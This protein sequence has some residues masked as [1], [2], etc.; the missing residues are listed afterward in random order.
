MHAALIGG[1]IVLV[2]GA[3]AKQIAS[4]SIASI[5]AQRIMQRAEDAIE[6][7]H[8]SLSVEGVDLHPVDALALARD[9]FSA[10]CEM[11][12]LKAQHVQPSVV[13]Q[14]EGQI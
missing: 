1:R 10:A 11:V 3:Y 8:T 4:T 6:D 12:M 13:V 14:A 2:H 5:S 9:L 7:G